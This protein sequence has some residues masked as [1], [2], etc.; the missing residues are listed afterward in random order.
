[1]TPRS[2]FYGIFVPSSRTQQGHSPGQPFQQPHD[3]ADAIR[4]ATW[5]TP[6]ASVPWF[7]RAG[8]SL[9]FHG[10]VYNAQELRQQLD[11]ADDVSLPELLMSAYERWSLDFVR[12]LDG[13]FCLALHDG[14]LL[15]LYRDASGAR[16]LYYAS[17]ASGRIACATHL[18]VLL[19]LPG[20]IK[21]LARRSLHE[22]LR[23]LEI[24]PPNTLYEGVFAL[25]AG[26]LA[27]WSGGEWNQHRVAAGT[28]EV[29]SPLGFEEV[30][31]ELQALL[32]DSIAS[33]LKGA[34]SPAAF[35]SG[36]VDSSLICALGA[37]IR[38]DLTA[39][40]VGFEGRHYDETP[41]ARRVAGHLRIT[42]E[43][44]HFSR[45]DH[46]RAFEA[47]AAG[48]EQ[49]MGDPAA[50]STLLAF[51]HCRERFDVN[52]D[53][54]GA[55]E[56]MGVMPPR[57]VR[58][59]TEYAALVPAG[60]RRSIVAGAKHVPGLAGYTPIFDFE[61]AAELMLRWRG[62]CRAEI[63][64]L[65][66]ESVS[67]DHTHFFQTFARYP[68]HAHFERS[69]AL[70]DAL[71]SDRLHQAAAIS[72]ACI[73]YPYWSAAVDGFV[74]SLPI[75]YRYQPGEP[76]R[77]LR[78]L[79]ARHV[80]PTIWNLP[81]HGFDFPLLEF[82][83]A[84]DFHLVRRYLQQECWQRWQ[85]VAPAGVA[86]IGRQFMAGNRRLM[87]RVWALVVLAAWLERHVD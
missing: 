58:I 17:D 66:G 52:L 67:F 48:A 23:F 5:S 33:R 2:G 31:N 7:A 75:A 60:L 18:D 51:E 78:A 47:F 62:F 76:K 69:S 11:A 80:P 55:D 49:P 3:S 30:L 72:G 16:N 25:Q 36:G 86:E 28:S 64:S 53:G 6:G 19:R 85:V 35:L 84:E 39:V 83:S 43:V 87:F 74:R 63:E 10:E 71:G 50:P 57:H 40:T 42:H 45:Q 4:T 12:Q 20:M 41:V 8:R 59:A 54:S 26:H 44:L 21:R 81:K 77:L 14:T 34:G 46:I 22:Y 56:S 24:A 65:C 82:L 61:H 79:L 27:S 38:P 1:M 32:H 13:I 70:L 15:H 9:A 68:R 37:R 29:S 73:R